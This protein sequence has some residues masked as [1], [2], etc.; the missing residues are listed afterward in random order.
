VFV[1]ELFDIESVFENLKFEISDISVI[2]M[3]MG[4]AP[5]VEIFKLDSK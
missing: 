2:M 1:L 4:L 5:K 3:N